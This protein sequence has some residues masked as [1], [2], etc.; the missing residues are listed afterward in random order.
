[1]LTWQGE[2]A[3]KNVELAAA[4]QEAEKLLKDISESTAVAEKEKAKVAVI[5]D[6]VS[7]TA[8]VRSLADI[9]EMKFTT[10]CSTRCFQRILSHFPATVHYLVDQDGIHGN[11]CIGANNITGQLF[12]NQSISAYCPTKLFGHKHWPLLQLA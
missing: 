3:I 7:K 8:S 4:S 12:C 10:L 6:Q 5:L 1:M 2:L 11:P 9:Y